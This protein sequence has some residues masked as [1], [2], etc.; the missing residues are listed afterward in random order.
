MKHIASIALFFAS[1]VLGASPAMAQ[2]TFVSSVSPEGA[3]HITIAEADQVLYFARDGGKQGIEVQSNLA[4]R[5]RSDQEWCKVA[6]EDN[7]RLVIDTDPNSGADGRTA[8]IIVYG[9]D[10]RSAGVRVE[11]L[12]NDPK[13]WTSQNEIFLTADQTD[14]TLT[15]TANVHYLFELP[16][17]ISGA[18]ESAGTGQKSYLFDVTPLPEDIDERSGTIKI[19]AVGS[20][21]EPVG[22][23][24]VQM[25]I[26]PPRFGVISDIHFGNSWGEGPNVKVPKALKNMV[27][28]NL[29]AIFICGDLTDWGTDAQWTQFKNVLFDTNIV[30][31]DLPV[32]FMMGNHDHYDSAGSVCEER[33]KKATGQ[34][35]HQYVE[36]KGYPFITLSMNGTSWSSYSDEC[37]NFL[38]SSLEDAAVKYPG[39]P[40]F[41]F[42]HVPPSGTVYGSNSNDGNWGTNKYENVLKNFPQV[43]I[44]SGHS[45]YPLGDPRS[46][47]Q[48]IY[49][50]VND[51]STTYGEVE[52]NLLSEGIHP[53]RAGWVTEGVIVNLDHKMNIEMERW[54]TYR[55][56]EILPRWY[57]NAPHNGSAFLYKNRNGGEDPRFAEGETVTISDVTEDGCSVTFNQAKDDELVHHYIIEILNGSSVV[58]T[59]KRFSGFYLN[60]EMPEN[61]SVTMGGLP[62][63]TTL[64]ARVTAVDSYFR[65]S[66][67]I[68]SAPFKTGEYQP[69]PGTSK[70]VA[71]LL[72]LEFGES[73]V[74]TDL[75]PLGNT[76]VTG[77]TKPTT[78]FSPAFDRWTAK[79]PGS[80]SSFYRINYTSDS[81]IGNALKNGFTFEVLYKTNNTN[82]VCPMSAQE[83]GGAGIEQASGGQIQFWAHINGGYQKVLGSVSAVSGSYYHVIAIY[84]KTAG[85]I[86]LYVNGALAGETSV[87]GNLALPSNTAAHWICVGGDASTGANSQYALNGEVIVARMYGKAVSRDE[88]YWMNK[89]LAEGMSRFTSSQREP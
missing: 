70:P 74:V 10:N 22:I 16:A 61:L 78:E 39:K 18:G 48:N 71:D 59:N 53:D 88:V 87:S 28:Q 31:A 1:L 11:Q 62:N 85:K 46:M 49:T 4:L 21:I 23:E 14:F 3:S 2:S 26:N 34:P 52:P 79:F 15:V 41:V 75:S 12:G 44:F 64:S 40:I 24:V 20:A 29:D 35:L 5:T 82:N 19:T 36:I 6:I 72:D 73:G 37:I 58:S 42:T 86:A 89:D 47:H 50:S 66:T 68:V 55:N 38:K 67:P 80:T 57:V 9:K 27:A 56:E 54:D 25:R 51:G 32:Y 30:P 13:I 63:N 76:I 7:S 81:D 77:S 69:Q 84:N 8:N 83:S 60:S 65:K 43:V 17:W 45:H 33:Y